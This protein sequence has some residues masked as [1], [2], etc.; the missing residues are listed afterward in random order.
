MHSYLFDIPSM[1]KAVTWLNPGMYFT[2]LTM[3]LQ[4]ESLEF[5]QVNKPNDFIARMACDED[6]E[7]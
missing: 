6:R 5:D 7:S 3:T 1:P 2:M 4:C